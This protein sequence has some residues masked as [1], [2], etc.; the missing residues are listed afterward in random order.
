MPMPKKRHSNCRQGK[1]RF[2]N[3]RLKA[4]NL[5]RCTQCGQPSLSHRACPSCGSYKGISAIKI[6]P[7]PAGP[8]A[9]RTGRQA[10]K[11]KKG[12]A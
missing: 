7:L 5:G 3:Y 10:K 11:A 6:K 9:G 12:K 4:K 2:S 1:R 8:P